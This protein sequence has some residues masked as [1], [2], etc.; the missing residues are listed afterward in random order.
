[1][2]EPATTALGVTLPYPKA[3]Q[4]GQAER[5]AVMRLLREGRL[6]ETQRGSATAALEDAFA[7]MAGTAHALSFTS[8]TAALHAA[9]HAAGTDSDQGVL[10]SPMTWL[11]A[12]TAV[13]HAGSF[14]LFADLEP[15]GSSNLDPRAVAAHGAGC[16]VVMVT[17][18]WGIPA[19]MDDL[20]AATGRPVIED[21]SHAHGALYRGRP[22]GS[23]GAAGVFST[24]ERKAVSGGEGGVLTTR[25]REIYERALVLGHHPHRLE[26]ELTLKELTPLAST[27]CGY[28]FRMPA[29]AAVIAREQLRHLPVRMAAAETNLAHLQT[30]LRHH[31]AP[32]TIPALGEG[33]VRGWYGTPLIV[34]EPVPDPEA[35]MDAALAA[36]IPLRRPYTDWLRTPLFH[37]LKQLQQR[38]PHLRISPYTP[39]D[40]E[41]FPH[42]DQARRQTLL[43]KI[44]ALPAPDYMGQVGAGLARL[45]NQHL[46]P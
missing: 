5:A 37:D 19:A 28:Q 42:Y 43:L 29:L 4:Y 46:N 34:T 25:S 30:V 18:A 31:R 32:L 21:C 7:E 24:Q 10:V 38:W 36:S 26:K 3:A 40:P 15:G 22:V 12:L 35:L 8:G 13:F 33:T 14:P 20:L 41:A 1:M 45:L 39:P 6:S 23:W 27:G 44:P 9:I 16:S 2:P 11:S 17:H